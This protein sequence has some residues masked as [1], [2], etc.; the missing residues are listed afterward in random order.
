MVDHSLTPKRL[1]S[2]YDPAALPRVPMPRTKP[3]L[4]IGLGL[5][6][7]RDTSVMLM[8][9]ELGAQ[10]FHGRIVIMIMINEWTNSAAEM[11]AKFTAEN[12][13][14]QGERRAAMFSV[15]RTSKWVADTGSEFQFSDGL[16][17][18]GRA[19]KETASVQMLKSRIALK[20]WRLIEMSSWTR[21]LKSVDG[22]ET[23][24]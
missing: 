23:R 11:L 10:P 20:C 5:F 21:L 22:A 1:R 17:R 15:P 4:L 24:L 9:Q 14:R 7:F 13:C 2:G 18:R 16:H 19:S 6:A 3:E 8:T 12:G